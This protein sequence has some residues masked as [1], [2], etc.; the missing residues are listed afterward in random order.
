[1]IATRSIVMQWVRSCAKGVRLLV[2]FFVALLVAAQ[3]I[4]A[5]PTATAG[6]QRATRAE[7]AAMAAAAEV[8]IRSGSLKGG[9]LTEE[10]ARLA[11]IK[12]RLEK[13]DFR[14][15]DRFVVTLRH[16][17]VRLDT[18]SVR[19]SLM[20]SLFALPDFTV[21]GVLRSELDTKLNTHVSTYLRNATVRA[22]VLTRISIFGAVG[23]PGFYYAAPDRP[24][25]DVLTLAGGVTAEAKLS[26]V[27][28]FRGKTR[29]LSAKESQKVLESGATLEQLDIQ[30]G[31][32]VR[33]PAKRKRIPFQAFVQ[34]LFVISTLFFAT[35]QFLQWYYNRQ[36]G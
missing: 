17:A 36:D 16:D 25:S 33:V 35:L 9:K 22:N 21:A 26:Q 24:L 11:A 34:L 15:G 20:V 30:S 7:L 27:E 23:S 32:E 5:Q 6:P 13:G 31:D 4:S 14:V 12:E 19:D 18:A 1:M 29:R 3:S 8:N 10:K 28:V 2:P